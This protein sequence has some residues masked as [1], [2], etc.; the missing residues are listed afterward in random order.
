M[1]MRLWMPFEKE[2]V[3][4]AVSESWRVKNYEN[5]NYNRACGVVFVFSLPI[6]FGYIGIYSADPAVGIRVDL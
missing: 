4:M 1:W 3:G 5:K 2:T 6:F